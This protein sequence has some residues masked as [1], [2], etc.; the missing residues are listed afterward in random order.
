M[1]FSN[2][3]T[4]IMA[5]SILEQYG[6]ASQAINMLLPQGGNTADLAAVLERLV[7][8][9]ESAQSAPLHQSLLNHAIDEINYDE[10]DENRGMDVIICTTA[11]TNEEAKELLRGFDMPFR[12]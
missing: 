4:S 2:P 3:Q 12:N 8:A 1:D 6:D 7:G 11:R 10:V 5:R 9:I